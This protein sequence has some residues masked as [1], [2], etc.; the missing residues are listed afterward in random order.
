M[1]RFTEALAAVHSKY[2]Y[3]ERPRGTPQQ[4]ARVCY[5]LFPVFQLFSRTWSSRA[6]PAAAGAHSSMHLIC[7]LV[8]LNRSLKYTYMERP[9]GTP[10]Q[11]VSRVVL[12]F[13]ALPSCFGCI[14]SGRAAPRSS[15]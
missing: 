8:R 5:P 9:R 12:I 7:K 11:Q 1:D 2:T 4:Q 15:R 14:W 6:G 10:Q 13:D 3:M